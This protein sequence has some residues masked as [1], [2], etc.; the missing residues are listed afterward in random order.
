MPS[1]TAEPTAPPELK[2]DYDSHADVLYVSWGNEPGV[3]G[4]EV[5]PNRVVRLTRAGEPA[6]VTV[7]DVRRVYKFDPDQD[8]PAQASAIALAVLSSYHPQDR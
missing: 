3:C 7:Y 8:V 4:D 5:L 6:G 1:P 2:S